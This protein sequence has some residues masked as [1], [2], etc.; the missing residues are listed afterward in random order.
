MHELNLRR[1][2][3]L[4]IDME[5]LRE[6]EVYESYADGSVKCNLCARR[7]IIK[8]GRVGIC[9]VRANIDGKLY[10]LN[11]G[12]LNGM[13]PDPIEKKPLFHFAPGSITFSISTPGCNFRCQFC[14]NHHTVYEPLDHTSFVPPE[15]IVAMAQRTNSQGIS[16]TYSEPTVF[17][18]TVLDTSKIAH[19]LG[20]YNTLVTN[21]YMTPE[22]IDLLAPYIDAVSVDFKGSGNIFFYRRYM[23][24]PYPEP[25]FDALLAYKKHGIHIEITNLIIPEIGDYPEDTKKLARWVADNLGENTPFHITAFHPAFKIRNIPQ[26]S[27]KLLL[28]HLEIVR[29]EGLTFVYSGNIPGMSTESTYCPNCGELVISRYSVFLNKNYATKDGK[30]PKCGTDLNIAGLNWMR[31]SE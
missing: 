24:V 26:T 30:C 20:L 6:A 11:Y 17:F 19:E 28:K 23:G 16:Y 29:N 5:N 7:C 3:I 1:N 31:G 12:R 14:Q 8:P 22:A 4:H 10:S 25:I 2:K 18:E 13:N 9:R 27:A 21:G 15:I